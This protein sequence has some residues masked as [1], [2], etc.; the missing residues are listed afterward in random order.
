MDLFNKP[1]NPNTISYEPSH[2]YFTSTAAPRRVNA[3]LKSAKIVFVLED[4]VMI[5]YDHYKHLLARNKLSKSTFTDIVTSQTNPELLRMRTAILRPG[6]Y[7][8][9]IGRW[10]RFFNS[11]QMLIID[12]NELVNQPVNVMHQLQEFLGIDHPLQYDKQLRW[13]SQ[14]TLLD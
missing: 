10:M 3:L 13:E 9:H 8:E 1:T 2:S 11:K 4:P 5:A 7:S 14:G 6:H 12:L